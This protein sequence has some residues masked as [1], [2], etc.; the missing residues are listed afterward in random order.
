MYNK[1]P[2]DQYAGDEK[3]HEISHKA[4]KKNFTRSFVTIK[5]LS[6]KKIV[7]LFRSRFAQDSKNGTVSKVKFFTCYSD[8]EPQRGE[9]EAPLFGVPIPLFEQGGKSGLISDTSLPPKNRRAR[10][11]V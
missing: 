9:E 4:T 6:I 10:R 1:N 2:Q 8:S 7:P 11:S 5:I 3:C